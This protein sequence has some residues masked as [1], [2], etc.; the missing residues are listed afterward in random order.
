[1]ATLRSEGRV[2]QH[3][4]KRIFHAAHVRDPPCDAKG[5]TTGVFS[6]NRDR[7]GIYIDPDDAT[8]AEG[9]SRNREDPVPASRV[10]DCPARQV[11]LPEGD[12]GDFRRE[13][14][15]CRILFDV[16]P[17]AWERLQRL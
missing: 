6:R 9:R 7:L 13:P 12:I 11:A 1:M 10:Q 2:H 14:C 4:V 3:G 16:G 8:G 17:W 15:G 5:D